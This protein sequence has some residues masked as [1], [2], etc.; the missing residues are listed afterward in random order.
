MLIESSLSVSF[1]HLGNSI[2]IPLRLTIKEEIDKLNYIKVKNFHSL[3]DTIKNIKKTNH[4][5]EK[6][7]FMIHIINKRLETRT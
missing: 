3:K 7:V 1:L 5:V 4:K 6:E 2:W